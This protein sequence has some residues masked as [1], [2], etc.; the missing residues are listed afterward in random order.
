MPRKARYLWAIE[1]KPIHEAA[2]ALVLDVTGESMATVVR[3]LVRDADGQV[4]RH[5]VDW[6]Q[7][8]HA[9]LPLPPPIQGRPRWVV[10]H[11]RAHWNA[12]RRLVD[13]TGEGEPTIIRQLVLRRAAAIQADAR[14]QKAAQW[15]AFWLLL[16]WVQR[17]S[18]DSTAD[19]SR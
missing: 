19:H 18:G 4:Q 11:D 13:A 12:I 9:R 1:I 2:M 8:A 16:A 17:A 7:L 14:Q 5:G 6:W 3:S 15:A 10:E